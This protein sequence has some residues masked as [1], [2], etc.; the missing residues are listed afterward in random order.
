MGRNDYPATSLQVENKIK[1]L[2]RFYKNIISNN[3]KM[4]GR[5]RKTYKYEV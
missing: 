5:A 2:E 3:N 1:S 4:M